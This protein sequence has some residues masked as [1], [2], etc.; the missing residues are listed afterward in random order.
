MGRSSLISVSEQERAMAK[1]SAYGRKVVG[2]IVYNTRVKRY[3]SDGTTLMNN[4]Q[5]WK[6]HGKLKA[7]ITPEQAFKKHKAHQEAILA[8]IPALAAYRKALHDLAPLSKRWRLHAAVILMPNDPDGVWSEACDN[9]HSDNVSASVDE[10]AKLCALYCAL[11]E[12]RRK[13]MATIGRR[14]S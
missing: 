1:L 7:H 9:R 12:E 5:G 10:I 8:D 6:R 2:E 3:M 13:R 14:E 11:E 4:G